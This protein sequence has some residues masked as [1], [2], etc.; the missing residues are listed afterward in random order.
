LQHHIKV[1]Q[2]LETIC[3]Q[4]R[5]KKIHGDIREEIENHIV[6]QKEAFKAQGFNDETVTL[7]AL[8]QMGDPII[9]GTE[10]DRT[11][12]PKP[13][14]SVIT[15]TILLLAAGTVIRFFTSPQDFNG[16]E[17]FNKQL[18]FTIAGIVLMALFYYMDFTI[19]GKYP[20]T[21]FL[22]LA[23]VTIFLTIVSNPINGKYVYASYLLLLFPISFA[24]FVYNMRNRGY[25][26]VVR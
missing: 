23:A 9:I 18:F 12:R 24:G 2:Y 8:E 3:S 17:L 14:W 13:E 11:H 22:L 21:I 25:I 1:K 19:L 15:L 4:I 20:K 10:L 6:D 7:K 26:G 5:C 16:I